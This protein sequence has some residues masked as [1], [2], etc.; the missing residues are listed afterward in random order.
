MLLVERHSVLLF[1]ST[2]HKRRNFYHQANIRLWRHELKS[3]TEWRSTKSILS[4]YFRLYKRINSRGI[5]RVQ[6]N[7]N[8]NYLTLTVLVIFYDLILCTKKIFLYVMYQ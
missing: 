2:D 1:S 5:P 3:R 7:H 8:H 6:Y 4:N